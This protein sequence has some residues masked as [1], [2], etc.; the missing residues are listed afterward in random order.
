MLSIETGEVMNCGADEVHDAL[1][2]TDSEYARKMDVLE[3]DWAKRRLEDET[4]SAVAPPPYVLPIVFHIVHENGAEN[5]SDADVFRSVDFLNQA[6]E[7][8]DYYDPSTGV[9]TQIQVCLARR[10]PGNE[11]SNGINRIVSPLTNLN[12]NN[13]RALK[14]LS[15]WAPR[16]YVN[17]WLVKEACG[18]GLGCNLAGYAYYPGAHG[19]SVDGIVME[20]RWLADDEA[21]LTVLVHELG[22]YLGVRHTFDGGCENDDCTTDGDRVCDTPPDQSTVAVPCTGSANS[23]DTDTDSGPF[24][25]DQDDM[26]INYMDY[27]YFRCYSAFTAGQRE[28]M[29][30]FLEGTRRSLLESRGCEEPCPAVATAGF[31]GGDVTVTVGETINF[32][33]TS[34]NGDR[35]EWYQGSTLIS[36]DENLSHLFDEDGSF[37]IR[38]IV[39]PANTALCETVELT[40]LVQVTC[41][42]DASFDLP[43]PAPQVD[44]MVVFTNTS[45]GAGENEWTV[46]GSVVSSDTDLNYTFTAPGRY[47]VCLQ[48]SDQSCALEECVNVFVR[49]PVVPEGCVEKHSYT[50]TLLSGQVSGQFNAV[51]AIGDTTFAL[52]WQERRLHAIAILPGGS[53]L[54]Q[55][56]LLPSIP[57]ITAH[58][59]VIDQEGMLV[60]LANT[61][62]SVTNNPLAF[63]INPENG[64]LLWA[65]EYI[66]GGNLSFSSIIDSGDEGVYRVTGYSSVTQANNGGFQVQLDRE[67]GNIVIPAQRI[68]NSGNFFVRDILKFDSALNPY[69]I[70]AGER[71]QNGVQDIAIV[72]TDD[73]GNVIASTIVISGT[74][75]EGFTR[76]QRTVLLQDQDS[77]LIGTSYEVD[78]MA[79][80][81]LCKTDSTGIPTWTKDYHMPAGGE[82]VQARKNALGYLILVDFIFETCLLQ[83]DSNGE[84]IWANYYPEVDVN[85]TG[86]DAIVVENGY[87]LLA[88]SRYFSL[89]F[90]PTILRLDK[91][92]SP[93]GTCTPVENLIITAQSVENSPLQYQV[94]N[95]EMEMTSEDFNAEP[96]N[97]ILVDELTCREECPDETACIPSSLR[98]YGP[99]FIAPNPPPYEA[100]HHVEHGN[101]VI[102]AGRDQAQQPFIAA[103]GADGTV[104]WTRGF[105]VNQ[106]GTVSDMIIDNEGMVCGIGTAGASANGGLGSYAFRLDPD[107]GDILWL[108]YHRRENRS[109]VLSQLHHTSGD[110]FLRAAGYREGDALS[111]IS[112]GLIARIDLA[113]GEILTPPTTYSDPGETSFRAFDK[114]P[115]SDTYYAL[116]NIQQS[117]AGTPQLARINADGSVIFNKQYDAPEI[118]QAVAMV[119]KDTTI[120]MLCERNGDGFV[121]IQTDLNGNPIW[122]KNYTRGASTHGIIPL[123]DGFMVW[124]NSSPSSSNAF[125][126]LNDAG[127]IV[128]A[129]RIPGTDFLG[130]NNTFH[131]TSS[132][133][134]MTVS[135]VNGFSNL[136]HFFG[137]IRSDLSGEFSFGCM[138]GGVPILVDVTESSTV[139]ADV[140]LQLGEASFFTQGLDIG[141][142]D[143][144]VKE[145]CEGDCPEEPELVEL[146]ENGIDDDEDGLLD[147]DDP[148]LSDNC[149]CL[150]PPNPDFGEDQILCDGFLD[151]ILEA[152]EN[153]EHLS[154][155]RNGSEIVLDL[156]PNTVSFFGL[157][158]P[159]TYVFEVTDTCGKSGLDTL[160]LFPFQPPTL[161]LGPDTTVC[162]NATVTLTAQ[163]GF[164][165]YEWVDG[166]TEEAFTAFGEGD[167]WVRVLDSCGQVFIDTVTVTVDPGSKIDLG[168]DVTICPGDTLTFRL[169]GYTDIQWAQSSFI[170]CFDCPEV[171]FS[172]TMDT[173]LLVA[174][175][176]NAGC[177]SSDSL[178]VRIK[179]LEGMRDTA[180]LCR[181]DTITYGDQTITVAGQ[182]FDTTDESRCPVI[183]TLDVFGLRDTFILE[184]IVFCAGDSALIFGIFEQ[185]AGTYTNVATRGNG[186]DSI[187]QVVLTVNQPV[188]TAETISICGG[189]SALV[190]GVFERTPDMYLDI[191]TG[192]NGCDS[193]HQITLE[194]ND[195]T[196]TA[197]QVRPDCEGAAAGAGQV[198]FESN[199]QPVSIRWSDNTTSALNEDLTAGDYTVT[200]TTPDGCSATAEVTIS[201]APLT[202]IAPA[203]APETCPGEN[204]GIIT[205]SNA[206]PA[207]TYSL[208]GGPEQTTPLFEDLPPGRYSLTA[209]DGLGCPQTFE[210]TINA[211]NDLVF[212]LPAD[213]TVNYGDSVVLTPTTLFPAE[214]TINWLTDNGFGCPSCPNLTLRPA[215]DMTVTAIVTDSS[216]CA[217]TRTTRISVNKNELFYVPNAFSPNADGINDVFR[218]YPGPAVESI[219]SFAV[220]DRWGGQVFFRKDLAPQD[221]LG[222][223]D[224]RKTDGQNPS[225][226][227]YVYSVEVR[228]F[229]GKVISKAGEVLLMR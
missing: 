28:R 97:L 130:L 19:S 86:P 148:D 122:Q 146:C 123:P 93:E 41:E 112:N 46:D 149:C 94:S 215:E 124:I 133:A 166:S 129:N 163:P 8:T 185:E 131:V 57:E 199:G 221:A 203:A 218:V 2:K 118:G 55:I 4:K 220:Y 52:A 139:I 13:D 217:Q 70:L 216:G 81:R 164:H 135:T 119:V 85:D 209:Q 160:I 204:D 42:I 193:T 106:P 44:S 109:F 37:R 134:A 59:L 213:I 101:N 65:K 16:D 151:F 114:H 107:T 61:R 20:A 137:L 201:D 45:S 205:I 219:L 104:L 95:A 66:T 187:N 18:I 157:D 156:D 56:E 222:H 1:R 79:I 96:S 152:P 142:I 108:K 214:A 26:H 33:N 141:E 6:L 212:E 49:E 63:R 170:D 154:V 54:W 207:F 145:S 24:T 116:A 32:I 14:D 210:L 34:T 31:T 174:A 191:G 190:F 29:H 73:N 113:T 128:W 206:P 211:A 144:V 158:E 90:L 183:D 192:S 83:I 159:G 77:L 171:R 71:I 180:Y 121:L 229:D 58:S 224:G 150:D 69:F 72:R 120:T 111:A 3:A 175:K 12:T 17:V 92:G 78:N 15:R 136:E 89:K 47:R 169:D 138:L 202:S 165:L 38:L 67:N 88:G 100:N 197:T 11:P 99:T 227:V 40:Q 198:F 208:D 75:I 10:S 7:N 68:I 196:A 102:I 167:F 125:V 39:H 228:L 53:I 21:D 80:V 127:D 143:L 182:Y 98:T 226:G 23:C 155:I 153:W 115:N 51:V 161:D 140:P 181:G 223:W 168:E 64:M 48:Q 126:R 5:I 35:Y 43:S 36:T 147:C 84:V 9:N 74:S 177:F 179:S 91:D 176:Q 25:S 82:I 178:R 62:G 22:H 200:V 132:G 76:F 117:S 162:E 184:E 110:N 173:L 105:F 172:P 189:D 225:I 27:G 186:C 188:L 103:I 194:V 60:G 30:F 50:Y 87:I 195:L